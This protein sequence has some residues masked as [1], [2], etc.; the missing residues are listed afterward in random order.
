M[1]CPDG[2]EVQDEHPDVLAQYEPPAQTVQ[3][4]EEPDEN[5]PTGHEEHDEL[6]AL[7]YLPALHEEQSANES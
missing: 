5:L 7:E 3:E 1:W 6:P 4:E 2:Q